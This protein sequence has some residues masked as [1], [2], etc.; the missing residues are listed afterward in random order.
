MNLSIYSRFV[1]RTERRT[2]RW[3]IFGF[4]AIYLRDELAPALPGRSISVDPKELV[5]FRTSYRLLSYVLKRYGYTI[6]SDL[7]GED[8]P[9]TVQALM[10][11]IDAWARM[12]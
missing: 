7:P 9:E 5:S 3:R 2:E 12:K 1:Y 4:D 6:A 8:R 11:E 10:C